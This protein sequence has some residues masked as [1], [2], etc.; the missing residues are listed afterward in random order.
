MREAAPREGGGR[1]L[2]EPMTAAGGRWRACVLPPGAAGGRRKDLE[3][4]GKSLKLAKFS[5]MGNLE[6][7]KK[8]EP[9]TW[10]MRLR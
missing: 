6:G 10:S 8:P 7:D 9:S 2:E 3:T 4:V 1:K 5:A